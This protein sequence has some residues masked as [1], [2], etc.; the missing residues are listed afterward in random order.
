VLFTCHFI[1]FLHLYEMRKTIFIFIF[2]VIYI[3]STSAQTYLDSI[4]LFRQQY[5][6]DFIKEARSP[7]KAKDTTW[8]RFYP[9]KKEYRVLATLKLTPESPT[10]D[11]LTHS[12]KKQAYRQYCIASFSLKGKKC[13]LSIYQSLGLLGKEE[14]KNHL[15]LPFNDLTNYE[16]SY[17]GGRYI[18]L[19]IMDVENGTIVID[20]NKCY[21]PYCAFKEGYSCPIPPVENRMKTRVEAGEQLFAGKVS[22]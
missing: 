2:C 22:E 21:N 9:A 11:M 17:A 13:Q 15:F 10:F 7:L 1:Y 18:D 19:S 16:T 20:F 6:E 5:K 8:L 3:G 14:H 12:G 4:A